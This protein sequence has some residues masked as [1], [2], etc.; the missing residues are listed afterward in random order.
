[1]QARVQ[2]AAAFS[3]L[4]A[5]ASVAAGTSPLGALSAASSPSWGG[6]AAP[7]TPAAQATLPA[8]P[9]PRELSTTAAFKQDSRLLVPPE[10]MLA[11]IKSKMAEVFA[12]YNQHSH[13]YVRLDL[14]GWR[15][16]PQEYIASEYMHDREVSIA[17][18]RPPRDGLQ[19]PT[20]VGDLMAATDR[21]VGGALMDPFDRSIAALPVHEQIDL[22]NRMWRAFKTDNYAKHGHVYGGHLP[23]LREW[24]PSLRDK[25]LRTRFVADPEHSAPRGAVTG[26]PQSGAAAP[27]GSN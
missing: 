8:P 14:T 15:A 10:A 3:L 5:A 23:A 4:C 12:A 25:P 6:P 21:P 24:K 9:T 11:T 13:T 17:L 16:S 1:M 20:R 22:L 26:P 27:A 2:I 7:W 18:Y 19:D